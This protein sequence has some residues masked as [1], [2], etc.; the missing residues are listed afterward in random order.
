MP[1]YFFHLRFGQRV[2]RDE[3]GI[4]LPNRSAARDEEVAVVHD[5]ANPEMGSNS[6]RWASWFLEVADEGG[7][8]FRT[9]IGHPALEIVTPDSGAPRE[10]RRRRPR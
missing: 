10:V 4:E 5:L 6:K 8:F 3:E 9:P 2:V 7:G 1:R